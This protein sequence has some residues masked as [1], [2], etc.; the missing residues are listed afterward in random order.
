MS[1]GQIQQIQQKKARN[2]IICKMVRLQEVTPQI[3]ERFIHTDNGEPYT[4]K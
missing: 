3:F 1:H 2:R 4:V